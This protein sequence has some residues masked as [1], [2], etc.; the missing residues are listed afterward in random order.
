MRPE[1]RVRREVLELGDERHE[2][3]RDTHRGEPHARTRDAASTGEPGDG[4]SENGREADSLGRR[5]PPATVTRLRGCS[6]M[7]EP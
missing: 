2:H 6:S 4:K 5:K 1:K 3:E 7:V